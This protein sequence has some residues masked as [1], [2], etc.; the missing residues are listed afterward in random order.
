MIVKQ[1]RWGAKEENV[2]DGWLPQPATDEIELVKVMH[3]LGDPVRMQLLSVFLDGKEHGCD[4]SG[5]GLDHLHK[6][7]VSHHMR[8]LR[9][10]GVTATRTVG[11]NRL[12]QLRKADLDT[13]FPGLT[14][15]LLTAM[16]R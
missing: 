7:T 9:E 11:R 6:S 13:R 4:L 3:A 2:V 10:A 5:L 1:S 15:A 14:D 16:G 12:V 8:V